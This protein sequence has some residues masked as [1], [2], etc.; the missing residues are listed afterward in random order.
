MAVFSDLF[1][2]RSVWYRWIAF[3]VLE[4]IGSEILDSKI[5]TVFRTNGR[6]RPNSEDEMVLGRMGMQNQ[7]PKSKWFSTL[8]YDKP[9][10]K[11]EIVFDVSGMRTRFQRL[12]GLRRF[13]DENPIP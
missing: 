1:D 13:N 4:W 12:D 2:S 7:I 11:L 9:D 5:E 3:K 10:F 6:A 8:G